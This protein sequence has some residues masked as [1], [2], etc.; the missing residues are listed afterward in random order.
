MNIDR[1][2]F[3][4]DAAKL[5]DLLESDE[6]PAACPEILLCKDEDDKTERAEGIIHSLLP[7][8]GDKTVLDFGCGEGHIAVEASKMAKKSVGYDVKAEGLPW[9]AHKDVLTT[10][11]EVV[12]KDAPYDFVVLY[13]VLDHA[14]DPVALL[15][16]VKA[17]SH[18]KTQIFVRCH[19]WIGRHA[20]HL[21]NQ[22]NKAWIHVVF[23]EEELEK[24][25]LKPDVVQKVT[26]PINQQRKWFAQA[27]LK[28]ANE[29]VVGGYVED[30]FRKP[31]VAKR[32]PK[33]GGGFPEFQ[34]SQTFNDYLLTL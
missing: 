20:G 30:F 33:V 17:V 2:L 1:A 19:P 27:G 32:L 5:L 18:E 29:E 25:G 4:K 3:D 26:A 22:M 11:F 21:Y 24:M 8:L 31:I 13:D 28:V 23:T 14:V 9:D 15:E 7:E 34:M 10:D 6:W 12:K 16:Q